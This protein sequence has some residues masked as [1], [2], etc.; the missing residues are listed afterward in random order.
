MNS[1]VEFYREEYEIFRGWF[2]LLIFF[3]CFRKA[4]AKALLLLDALALLSFL[5]FFAYFNG[6]KFDFTAL[7]K[8]AYPVCH[9]K[10]G[11]LSGNFRSHETLEQSPLATEFCCSGLPTQ[12]CLLCV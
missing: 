4:V 6:K 11:C 8:F 12:H 9:S 10:R 2:K 3:A 1:V 7:F 5:W